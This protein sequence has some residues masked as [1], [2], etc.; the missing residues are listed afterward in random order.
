MAS[1]KPSDDTLRVTVTTLSVPDCKQCGYPMKLLDEDNQKW[2]CYKDDKIYYAKQNLWD[3]DIRAM[4]VAEL[5]AVEATITPE[6]INEA[7]RRFKACMKGC[8]GKSEDEID[9]MINRC[10]LMSNN[11]EFPKIQILR[12]LDSIRQQSVSGG[13][14]FGWGPMGIAAAVALTVGEAAYS[15][16]RSGKISIPLTGPLTEEQK[17][18][19]ESWLTRPCKRCG[20][21]MRV[22][23][24]ERW[25]CYKDDLV[26]YPKENRWAE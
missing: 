17:A 25:Y 14:W 4:K 9:D 3:E 21:A 12:T 24:E 11:A 13:A 8:T 19:V 16:H 7:E 20:E 10:K 22:L 15:A 26:F 1:V 18:Q 2:Y 6:I 23:D 5:R